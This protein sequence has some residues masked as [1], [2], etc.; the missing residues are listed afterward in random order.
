MSKATEYDVKQ[1][2]EN[3]VYL[4]LVKGIGYLYQVGSEFF[5][6][7][8]DGLKRCNETNLLGY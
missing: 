4:G 3:G 7:T 1:V 2:K 5:A 6:Y 8:G